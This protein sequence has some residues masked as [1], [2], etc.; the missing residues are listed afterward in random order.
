MALVRLEL[1][2]DTEHTYRTRLDGLVW[3]FHFL[4]VPRL[5]HFV[6]SIDDP[7]GQRV[8]SGRALTPNCYHAL[9]PVGGPPGLL[10][11]AAQVETEAYTPGDVRAERVRL[12]YVEALPE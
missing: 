6:L 12:F 8:I 9:G 4:Y 2:P 3:T 1:F 5:A 10:F 7:N 11:L